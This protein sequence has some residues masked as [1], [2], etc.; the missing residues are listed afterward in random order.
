[1]SMTRGLKDI[2][3]MQQERFVHDKGSQ[4]HF[5]HEAGEICS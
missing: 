3:T 1:M 4:R 5:N 2:S